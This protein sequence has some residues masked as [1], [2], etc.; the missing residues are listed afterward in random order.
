M[1]LIEINNLVVKRFVYILF[2]VF[3]TGLSASAQISASEK[4]LVLKSLNLEQ[5]IQLDNDY[6]LADTQANVKKSKGLEISEA[7]NEH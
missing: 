5:L 3:I 4:S 7:I 2:S 1:R 6:F